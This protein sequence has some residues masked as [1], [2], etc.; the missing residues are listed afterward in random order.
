MHWRRPLALVAW[1]PLA[2]ACAGSRGDDRPASAELGSVPLF[3]D[4]GATSEECLGEGK[5]EA[6]DAG[7]GCC[8]GLT[9]T[10]LYKG[11]LIRLD[12]CQLMPGDGYRCIRCGDGRCGLGENACNC[13]G[14]CR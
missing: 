14:E 3:Q 7:P 10:P 9:R 13:S 1:A 12:E 11:S 8:E 5:D 4:A 6:G 2:I